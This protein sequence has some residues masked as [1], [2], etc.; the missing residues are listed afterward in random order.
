MQNETSRNG[1]SENDTARFRDAVA[2]LVRD[3]IST[4][5]KLGSA[6]LQGVNREVAEIQLKMIAEVLARGPSSEFN[7]AHALYWLNVSIRN[8]NQVRGAIGE[9]LIFL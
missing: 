7:T 5:V 8:L 3:T 2:E 6:K 1:K 4:A 9:Y